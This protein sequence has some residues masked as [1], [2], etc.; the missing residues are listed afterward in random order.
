MA[1]M[2]GN[3][4]FEKIKEMNVDYKTYSSARTL[5]EYFGDNPIVRAYGGRILVHGIGVVAEKKL[6]A[7][8]GRPVTFIFESSRTA[9]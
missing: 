7:A 5:A 9:N 1:A 3:E 4:V 2:T 6:E 8:L